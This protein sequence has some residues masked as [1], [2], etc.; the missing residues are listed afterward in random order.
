MLLL[1]RARFVVEVFQVFFDALHIVVGATLFGIVGT[2]CIVVALLFTRRAVR[3]R[4][5]RRWLLV[6]R[7]DGIPHGGFTG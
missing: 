1:K 6:F 5:T 2:Q 7:H 3:I 4:C